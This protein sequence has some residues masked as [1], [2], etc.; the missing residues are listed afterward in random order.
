MSSVGYHEPVSELS[1]ETRDMH[2]A[3][4]SL[5]EELEAVDC[6]RDEQ[7]PRVAMAGN[8]PGDVDEVH[9]RAAEDVPER[10]G[11]VR[12]HDLHHLRGA[13]GGPFG[14]QHPELND[15]SYFE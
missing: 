3:I 15:W 9:H 11:I 7:A 13:F 5:M 1:E 6:R 8:R 12:Q 2:R 10:V 14:G 4:L